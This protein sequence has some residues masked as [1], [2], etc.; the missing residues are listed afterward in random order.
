MSQVSGDNWRR[1]LIWAVANSLG[2]AVPP[3]ILFLFPAIAAESGLFGVALILSLPLGIAQWLALRRILRV[4]VVWVFTIL[5]SVLSFILIIREIPGSLWEVLDPESL[6]VLVGLFFFLGFLTG[7]PQWLIFR[8]EAERSSIWLLSSALGA[9]LGGG[10]VIATN[11]VDFSGILA[12][13]VAALLYVFV[14]GY[15]ISFLL[16]PKD[17]LQAP[18]MSTASA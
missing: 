1:F 12:Y 11:L 6:Y 17:D 5:V 2:F 10:F 9:A 18:D 16:Q 13:N 14:T 4:S 15:A 7:L 8:R 3:A